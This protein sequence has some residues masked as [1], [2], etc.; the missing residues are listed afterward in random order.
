MRL[1]FFSL[2]LFTMVLVKAE[3]S[4]L[5]VF[6]EHQ[7]FQL[8]SNVLLNGSERYN[9][10]LPIYISGNNI[11]V[12]ARTGILDKA[13]IPI[14]IHNFTVNYINQRQK[15]NVGLSLANIVFKENDTNKSKSLKTNLF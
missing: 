12:Q 10:E 6:S 7:V 2:S 14:N 13:G 11:L 15:Q 3:I 1:T 4:L 8:E 5:N 9:E